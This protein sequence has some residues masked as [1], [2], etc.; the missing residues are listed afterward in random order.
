M[1]ILLKIFWEKSWFFFLRFWHFLWQHWMRNK[2]SC[3]R[4]IFFSF[5]LFLIKSYSVSLSKSCQ[6]WTDILYLWLQLT[7]SRY[8]NKLKTIWLISQ[9]SNNL[10][11]KKWPTESVSGSW[12]LWWSVVHNLAT[13]L[14]KH[15]RWPWNRLEYMK[16]IIFS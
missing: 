9:R 15:F 4:D 13:M 6:S 2:I 1:A 14:W 12:Q 10:F 7:E 5:Y 16:Y 11:W 8:S 3:R